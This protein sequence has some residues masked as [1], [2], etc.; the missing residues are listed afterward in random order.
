M[1]LSDPL[2]APSRAPAGGH[3]YIHIPFCRSRC[4]YCDFYTRCGVSERR[5][6]EVVEAIARQTDELLPLL[7]EEAGPGLSTIYLGGG[8]PSALTPRARA[9]LFT[10]V[11]ELGPAGETTLEVNPEDLTPELLEEA[12]RAGV[13]RLSLGVQSLDARALQRIGRKI[14]PRAVRSGID[15]IHQ[16]WKDSAGRRKRW[17]ADIIAAIPQRDR[18]TLEEDLQVVLAAG[19]DHLSIYELTLEPETL[20]GRDLRRGVFCPSPEE[21]ILAEGAF[22]DHFLLSRGFS[23]YEISNY[24]LPGG[25]SRH[26]SA[27]WEMRPYLGVGPGAVGTLLLPSPRRLT[28]S[29]DLALYCGASP[30]GLQIEE[31]APADHLKDIIMMG[32]RTARGVSDDLVQARFGRSLE[33]CIPETIARWGVDLYREGRP[34]AQDQPLEGAFYRLDFRYWTILNTFLREAF[35]EI[36]RTGPFPPWL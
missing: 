25:E 18:K 34:G 4:D 33:S 12:V 36:D 32:F 17:S 28:N 22:L 35:Q 24:A 5:Q 7:L 20:L 21:E 29:R 23:R 16:L 26:N 3:L 11:R 9:R 1:A 8:T 2:A 13:N 19:A 15:L 10:L 6:Y 27:Y 14:D 30:Q 31:I